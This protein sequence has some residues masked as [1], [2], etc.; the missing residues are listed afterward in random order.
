MSRLIFILLDGLRYDVALSSM[1][2]LNHLIEADK[3]ALY[4]VKAELPTLSR[5]GYATLFSGTNSSIH[6]ITTN[7]YLKPSPVPS[8]F[9]LAREK[10]LRT[11]AAA[12]SWIS[13]LYN[14]APFNPLTEREQENEENPI[15]FGRF[16][17]E[18][19]YPC[20]HLFADAESL[21]KK[22]DPHLLLIHPMSIDFKG[23]L[24]GGDSKEYQ[25]EVMFVDSLLASLIPVWCREGYHIIITSDHGM[26][27][28]GM[29]G[30][31]TLKERQVPLFTITP[32]IEAG[33]YRHEIPQTA[34]A[35]LAARMM[36]LEN[37]MPLPF[38]T[39]PGWQEE[40]IVAFKKAR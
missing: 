24:Y 9:H 40:K 31:N 11:A 37:V 3:A 33:Y 34:I 39:W 18:D 32:L 21:R 25:Q 36:Q 17:F 12:Y 15:Q 26:D 6:E 30:G 8:L 14:R 22:Y 27:E 23:H 20:T 4:L 5:P 35:P 38:K 29:H 2:F 28:K 19:S 10:N 1:G 7:T 13:E 16:Y